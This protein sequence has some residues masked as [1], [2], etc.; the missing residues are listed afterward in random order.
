MVGQVETPS[1]VATLYARWSAEIHSYAS[2]LLGSRDLAEDVTQEVFLAALRTWPLPMDAPERAW[3]YRVATNRC[4]NLLRRR[5]LIAWLPLS[6]GHE[7]P[8]R[9]DPV[10][11]A[12]AETALVR[13]VLRALKP[14]DATLLVLTGTQGLSYHEVARVLHLS[15][16]AAATA[17][18]RAQDRFVRRYEA[19][20]KET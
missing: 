15:P 18:S 12:A 10:G 11:E 7:H 1:D 9:A 13:E 3:L 5:R 6:V 19:L 16:G 17:I 2:R 4:L 14:R 20:S 8:E